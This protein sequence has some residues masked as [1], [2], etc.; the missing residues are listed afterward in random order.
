M[1]VSLTC[2]FVVMRKFECVLLA[3]KRCAGRNDPRGSDISCGMCVWKRIAR[4][5]R[6]D[7]LI[8]HASV[9]DR[10]VCAIILRM[11]KVKMPKKS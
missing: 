4:E 1:Q 8:L 10:R 5:Y 6:T 2:V 7:L 3:V 11:L 9:D